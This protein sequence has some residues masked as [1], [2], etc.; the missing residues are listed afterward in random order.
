MFTCGVLQQ[1]AP[2]P[3]T[4]PG[5]NRHVKHSPT[6]DLELNQNIFRGDVAGLV[7]PRPVRVGEHDG[8]GEA[9]ATDEGED[10]EEELAI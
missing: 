1:I 2:R 7:Q 3:A 5:R 9:A 4:I 10:A 8:G 6:F